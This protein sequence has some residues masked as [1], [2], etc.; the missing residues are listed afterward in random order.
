MKKKK[1]SKLGRVI[2]HLNSSIIDNVLLGKGLTKW[3]R[4][5]LKMAMCH[6]HMLIMYFKL[7]V[8]SKQSFVLYL[9]CLISKTVYICTDIFNTSILLPLV[10]FLLLILISICCL[11]RKRTDLANGRHLINSR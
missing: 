11:G 3:H 4:N 9:R 10:S 5:M 7:I 8:Y 1:K 6:S 2:Y